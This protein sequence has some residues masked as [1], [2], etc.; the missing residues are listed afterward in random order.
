MRKIL[1]SE[2][3]Q[4]RYRLSLRGPASSGTAGKYVGDPRI[5]DQAAAMLAGILDNYGPAV[6]GRRGRGRVL[7]AE[8]RRAGGRRRRAGRLVPLSTVQV[9]FYQPDRFGL[10]YTGAD[11]GTAPPGHG[12]PQRRRRRGADDGAPDRTARRRLSRLA[13]TGTARGAAG[14]GP[15]RTRPRPRSPGKP[16][17]WGCAPGS[18]DRIRAP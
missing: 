12:A 11:G 17:D 4:A 15:R 2:V 5:W 14:G 8:D 13:G 1:S 7:R 16:P 6:G 3:K 9:D 10:Q 18:P